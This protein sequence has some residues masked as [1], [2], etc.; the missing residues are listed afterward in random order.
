MSLKP[1]GTVT[2]SA[3]G[4][5]CEEMMSEL[6]RED[7]IFWNIRTEKGILYADTRAKNYLKIAKTA[8]KYQV[9]TRV[10]SKRGLYFRLYPYR[11]RLGLPIGAALSAL[12]LLVLECF[13]WK[14]Q[15]AGTEKISENQILETLASDGIHL[16]A[17]LS[18]FDVND[19]E[20]HLKQKIPGIAWISVET[21]GSTVNVFVKEANELEKSGISL[22]TPCNVVAGRSG[23]ILETTVYSGTLLYPAGSGVREGSVIVGGV[24]NDGAGHL[25][26]S[27]ASAEIIAEFTEKVSFSMPYTTKEKQATGR[28]E[29]ETELMLFGFVFPLSPAREPHENSVCTESTSAYDF[30]GIR[31]PWKIRT[32]TYTEYE[33][34][35]VTRKAS[36]AIR[37][38]ERRLED[39]C[40]IYS[41][42]EILGI[43][44][45]AVQ[46]ETGVTLNA[47]ITLK[48]DIAVQREIWQRGNDFPSD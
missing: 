26:L 38:L 9:R 12:L 48:G 6:I 4:A 22:K 13:V 8:R 41:D 20:V 7:V 1:H 28:T 15:V 42:Y 36:D 14:I 5:Y 23:T 35:T 40:G 21:S 29:T 25:L 45:E 30:M 34:V 24:V 32:Y 37:I 17:P 47:E 11:G 39:Y 10:V 43:Q 31:L 19:A 33:D 18:S 3:I 16:G 46:E 27:H 2:F 44:K